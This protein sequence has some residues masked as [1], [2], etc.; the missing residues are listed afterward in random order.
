MAWGAAGMVKYWRV[1]ERDADWRGFV[2]NHAAGN[3]AGRKPAGMDSHSASGRDE[4]QRRCLVGQIKYFAIN[5]SRCVFTE[6]N[7]SFL[8]L[9]NDQRFHYNICSIPPQRK[10]FIQL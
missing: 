7:P 3:R 10:G 2:A 9:I 8:T 4:L 1:K 5:A 6:D